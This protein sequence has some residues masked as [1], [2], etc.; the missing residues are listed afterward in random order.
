M[1]LQL[2]NDR[3]MTTGV[4]WEINN[5]HYSSAV[6]WIAGNSSAASINTHIL[7]TRTQEAYR[8]GLARTRNP[9][10]REVKANPVNEQK[11]PV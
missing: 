11:F 6:F 10:A 3:K 7:I 2:L 5:S 1:H 4:D 9:R 8:R